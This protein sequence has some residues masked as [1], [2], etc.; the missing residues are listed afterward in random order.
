MKQFRDD[1]EQPYANKLC[2]LEEMGKYLTT[3]G[4]W[5]NRKPL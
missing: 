4:S 2:S 3:T 1:Y 5:K